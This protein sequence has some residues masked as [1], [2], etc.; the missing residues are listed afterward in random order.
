MALQFL[1]EVNRRL[2]RPQQRKSRLAPYFDAHYEFQ[3]LYKS[4]SAS[5]SPSPELSRTPRS[6][7][8]AG[9]SRKRSWSSVESVSEASST[10]LDVKRRRINPTTR[11]QHLPTSR[12]MRHVNKHTSLQHTGDRA[13][14]SCLPSST[15]REK[16]GRSVISTPRYLKRS[17]HSS[18][19][20]T[21]LGKL[22]MPTKVTKK[23]K[24]KSTDHGSL[25]SN[26]RYSLRHMPARLNK[27]VW[28]ALDAT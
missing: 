27:A 18:L 5:R 14:R 4:P 22:R 11:K 21:R 7:W 12:Y 24:K 15:R 25:R 6:T 3:T 1:D 19:E 26:V 10:S 9:I 23:A 28:R 8:S 20:D 13:L 17:Q 2:H 16:T